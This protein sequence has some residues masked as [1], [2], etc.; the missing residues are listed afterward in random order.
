LSLL[1]RPGKKYTLPKVRNDHAGIIVSLARQQWPDI[2]QFN[3]P[4]IVWRMTDNEYHIGLIV[5]SPKLERVIER[6]DD[7]AQRVQRDYHASAPAPSKPKS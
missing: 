7:Y 3:D 4:E 1:S 6:L 5:Q 2:S